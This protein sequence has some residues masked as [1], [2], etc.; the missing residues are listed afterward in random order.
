MKKTIA[1]LLVAIM[2]VGSVFAAFTGEASIGF[3][4]NLDNGNFGFIDQST[5]AK[6]DLELATANAENAGDGDIYASVKAS[7]AVKLFNGEK[8][9]AKVKIINNEVPNM[10]FKVSNIKEKTT[11]ELPRLYYL[12]YK[13][14]D[15][16]GHEIKYLKNKNGFIS[17]VINKEGS[18]Y[19]TYPGT[20]GYQ[21][22]KTIVIITSIVCITIIV[23]KKRKQN[24]N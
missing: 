22:S 2:A 4:G 14:E 3:G 9:T 23:L 7:L 13:I 10:E 8:G 1:I 6:I 21:I 12:G 11:L 16:D 18:Y 15:E 20:L 5:N 17:I 19:V 24:N